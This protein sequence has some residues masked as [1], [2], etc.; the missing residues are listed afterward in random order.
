[1]LARTSEPG[2]KTNPNNKRYVFNITVL[3]ENATNLNFTD[4]ENSSN[5]TDLSNQKTSEI[6]NLTSAYTLLNVT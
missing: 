1:M 3:P 4:V 2:W 6:T 5:A